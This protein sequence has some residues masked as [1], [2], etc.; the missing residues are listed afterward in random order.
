M[1]R[2][3]LLAFFIL[4][5]IVFT[6]ASCNLINWRGES[7]CTH[8]KTDDNHIEPTCTEDG[9]Y[10]SVI[11]C[12]VCEEEFSRENIIIPATGHNYV[13]GVCEYCGK[14][15]SNDGTG[16]NDNVDG[17]YTRDGNYIY[18]GEYPQ[19]LKADNVSI[20]TN[21]DSRGYYLGS[22]GCYYAKVGSNFYKVEP[23]CWRILSENDEDILLLCENIIANM[24]Y[25]TNNSNNYKNS[26]VRAW[27]NGSFYENAFSQS[28]QQIIRTTKVDNSALSTG[29]AS[30]PNSYE[31]TED[32]IFLLSYA[33][34]INTNYGFSDSEY[35]DARKKIATEYARATGS[36]NSW[37]LR[38]HGTGST[39]VRQVNSSGSASSGDY[40]SNVRDTVYGIVPA[41][42]I[43]SQGNDH[44]HVSGNT[45][46]ENNVDATCIENGSY[47]NVVYCTECEV[48]IS[49]KTVTVDATGHN[50]VNG[51]CSVC[52]ES[53]PDFEEILNGSEGLSY[54]Y[55][56][57][58]YTVTGI[59]TCKDS[60]VVIPATYNGYPVVAIADNAF[61]ECKS[62]TTLRFAKDSSVT[63]IGFCAFYECDNL[64]T[65]QLPVSL[66]SFSECVFYGCQKLTEIYISSDNNYFSTIDGHLYDKN[67]T[68]FLQYALAK[69]NESFIVQEGITTIDRNAFAGAVYLEKLS[70]PK[71]VNVLGF[72]ALVGC[73]R[74][75][76]IIVDESNVAYKTINGD[77]YNKN[78]STLIQYAL[79]KEN[80]DFIVPSGVITIG[81]AAFED[82]EI[83]TSVHISK[84]VKTISSLAFRN[85]PNLKTV[86]FDENSSLDTIEYT[87]FYDCI[88][89]EE[90]R[91]PKGVTALQ[92]YAFYNCKNL[93]SVVIP[94]GFTAIGYQAFGECPKLVIYYGGSSSSWGT[95][96]IDSSGASYVKNATKY[97]YSS[98]RPS[99][100]GNYWYYDEND[101]IIIW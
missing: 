43:H 69:Q 29:Y 12:T 17:L 79:G 75:K 40:L 34:V 83:L 85:C 98:T 81:R 59:G 99:L 97:Y 73:K 28:H 22:D 8:I 82:C 54:S 19:T 86:E 56:N 25:S 93:V 95:V 37:R 70:L 32:K 89:L 65:V 77:L 90:F 50:Y 23:L 51:T 78:G 45:V 41:L 91:I 92:K 1:K 88:S 2:K 67:Q 21:T 44:V 60:N 30:N 57:G 13:N 7:K 9:S 3:F 14:F 46:V 6:F 55:S 100:D 10:D 38:S 63:D 52:G 48:E 101:N 11:Y 72:E 68:K 20:T 24:A 61:R 66:K 5:V 31:D 58:S 84:T 15:G 47:D 26:N 64:V 74:L 33:D 35:D 42:W 18:F 49:R 36:C 39:N 4:L 53:D 16:S 94:D 27:L 62:I 80:V 96:A 76:E 87:A 71:S